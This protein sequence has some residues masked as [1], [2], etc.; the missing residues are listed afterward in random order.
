MK[1]PRAFKQLE[2]FSKRGNKVKLKR[3]ILTWAIVIPL[4]AC[5]I[6]GGVIIATM[7]EVADRVR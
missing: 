1:E 7:A 3:K 5:T 2:R 6:V 4:V